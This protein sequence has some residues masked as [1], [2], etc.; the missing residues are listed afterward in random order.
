[1]N[2]SLNNVTGTSLLES[3]RFDKTGDSAFAKKVHVLIALDTFSAATEESQRK[4]AIFASKLRELRKSNRM[5]MD[6]LVHFKLLTW[7]SHVS[8]GT[9]QHI[10]QYIAQQSGE[11]SEQLASDISFYLQLE[12]RTD[13]QGSLARSLNEYHA[14]LSR[15]TEVHEISLICFGAAAVVLYD[16]VTNKGEP[17]VSHLSKEKIEPELNFRMDHLFFAGTDLN[18]FVACA[19]GKLDP[20]PLD[21]QGKCKKWLN[22]FSPYDRNSGPL[23]LLFEPTYKRPARMISS[24]QSPDSKKAGDVVNTVSEKCV[25]WLTCLFRSK[26]KDRSDSMSIEGYDFVLHRK[27]TDPLT[28][29]VSGGVDLYWS[30]DDLIYFVLS[31]VYN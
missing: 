21:I 7:K 4:G 12:H 28:Q 14:K 17:S 3:I 19:G 9:R 18:L 25:E 15:L 22:I 31:N 27:L 29:L 16:L 13:M 10:D 24:G 1:M 2:N 23:S 30:N 20:L 6:K 5:D 26:H 8:K 11:V